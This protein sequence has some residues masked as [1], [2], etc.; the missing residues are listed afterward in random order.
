MEKNNKIEPQSVNATATE[1]EEK[2]AK[3]ELDKARKIRTGV[4][5]GT[6]PGW[7]TA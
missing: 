5:A 1:A 6:R 2:N 7:R 4:R 3:V